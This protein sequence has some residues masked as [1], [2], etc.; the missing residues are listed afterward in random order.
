MRKVTWNQPVQFPISRR[1]FALSV[2]VPADTLGRPDARK[3]FCLGCCLRLVKLTMKDQELREGW[4]GF[5]EK[6]TVSKALRPVVVASWQR[7]QIHGIPVS[8]NE[9]PLAPEVEL[10][11]CRSVH[12]G[13]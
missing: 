5:V 12:S 9:A 2:P 3:S 10:T 8:R 7:S 11:Q 13:L 1:L 4:E 6:G